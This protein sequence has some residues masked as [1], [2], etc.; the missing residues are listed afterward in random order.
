[1]LAVLHDIALVG[2]PLFGL[3]YVSFSIASL[4]H[5]SGRTSAA[6]MLISTVKWFEREN[7]TPTGWRLQRC[8]MYA[9]GGLF[10]TF[11][12]SIAAPG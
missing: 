7:Y 1:M 3:A 2:F 4:F 6:R 10:L 5:L 12:M 9:V 11:M 8:S